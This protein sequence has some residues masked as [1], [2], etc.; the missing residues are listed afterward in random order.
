MK[1][2][3][4][5]PVDGP[6]EIVEW[7]TFADI[8]RLIEAEPGYVERVKVGTSAALAVHEEGRQR[9]LPVN[10]RAGIL[11]GTPIHGQ[12]IVGPAVYL[13]EEFVEAGEDSGIEF[14][15]LDDPEATLDMLRGLFVVH[16]AEE[17]F[18]PGS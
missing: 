7:S 13:K 15:G 16:G 3:I 10:P 4:K 14:T 1:K 9:G 6:L 2:A 12:P 5:I 17:L 18:F 8:D 11:Y